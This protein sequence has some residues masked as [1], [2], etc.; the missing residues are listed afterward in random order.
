MLDSIE[1]YIKQSGL[2]ESEIENT[3]KMP[4]VASILKKLESHDI[5]YR[6]LMTMGAHSIH[7]T[8]SSLIKD[9]VVIESGKALFKDAITPTHINQYVAVSL[10][11][12]KGLK[13]FYNLLYSSGIDFS[14]DIIA[15]IDNYTIEIIKILNKYESL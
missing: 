11:V 14:K 5:T 7:G 1:N 8:W 10:F 12:L 9:F 15:L 6:C 3:K 4:D 2:T 13:S